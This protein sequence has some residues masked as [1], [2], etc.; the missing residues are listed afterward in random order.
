L[1]RLAHREGSQG[2]RDGG[3]Q[4]ESKYQWLAVVHFSLEPRR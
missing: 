1:G 2:T 4:Q 3:N